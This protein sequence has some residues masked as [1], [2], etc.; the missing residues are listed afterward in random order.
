M[1]II[2]RYVAI[3]F[4]LFGLSACSDSGKN[5]HASKNKKN[6]SNQP[7]STSPVKKNN[8]PSVK[9]KQPAH[10]KIH[11]QPVVTPEQKRKSALY[12]QELA[13]KFS[14]YNT[15]SAKFTSMVTQGGTVASAQTQRGYFQLKRP[16]EFKWV[17]WKT[18]QPSGVAEEIV[19][20]GKFYWRY[21]PDLMQAIRNK[22]L[23]K[24]MPL[25]QLL[26]QHSQ[27]EKKLLSEYVISKEKVN[28]NPGVA[29][30]SLSA[31]KST[32]NLSF[33]SMKLCFMNNSLQKITLS[34]NTE[35]SVA[36]TF[37]DVKLN[38]A[39]SESIFKFIPPAGTNVIKNDEANQLN[40]NSA[41]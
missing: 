17:T 39:I 5:S 1:R 16:D 36:F 7:A 13:K 40:M 41:S 2:A 24:K 30:Y 19:G 31:I 38:Q 9:R 20:S 26:L 18:D 25:L 8:E 27:A 34:D 21:E 4:I 10:Q 3:F 11:S 37:T 22:L 28:N 29:C 33:R 32:L 15:F 6:D 35:H 23:L 12:A 14:A